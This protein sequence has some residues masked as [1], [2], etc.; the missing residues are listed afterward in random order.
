M[1]QGLAERQRSAWEAAAD[2]WDR[3]ATGVPEDEARLVLGLLDAAPGSSVIDVGCGNGR[4]C[5]VLASQGVEV[6]GVDGTAAL[7][8]RARSHD[9]GVDYR[10]IDLTDAAGLAALPDAAYD[11][12][13]ALTVLMN[14]ADIEPLAA[15]AARILAPGAPLVIKEVH[16]CFPN[17]W[18]RVGDDDAARG[19]GKA[20][21]PMAVL[22]R[23]WLRLTAAVPAAER[24]LQPVLKA[25]IKVALGRVATTWRYLEP[26]VLEQ[27]VPGQRQPHLRWHRP[28][29]ELLRPFFDHGFVLDALVEP[30]WGDGPG[31]AGM[32]VVR[33]RNAGAAR[34]GG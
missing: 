12:A 31:R 6:T 11:G 34:S 29:T 17:L 4:W 28:L 21:G 30:E 22:T 3:Y 15:A 19:D 9:D 2:N 7:V 1:G 20:R 8:E 16:P 18:Q 25:Y 23:T 10:R 14:L 5:R 27:A 24:A 32:V 13:L 33:L 26:A